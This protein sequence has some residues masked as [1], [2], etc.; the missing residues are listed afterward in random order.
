MFYPYLYEWLPFI[1]GL[2]VP[3]RA[4]ILVGL[5][6]ALLAGFGVR[7]L[8]GGRSAWLQRGVLAALVV[9]IAVDLRP[10]LRL[11]PVWLEPPPIYG[12][13]S[14][15]T[16]VVLAEFPF[17]GNP[18]GFTP[19]VPYMYFSLWHWAQM[20]NGYSGHYPPGQVDFE[21]A[22]KEFPGGASRRSVARARRDA[23]DHQLRALSRRL[24][25]AA[26][27]GRRVAR[28]SRRGLGQ[29]AGR[30]GAALRA[31]ADSRESLEPSRPER[32]HGLTASSR[33]ARWHDEHDGLLVIVIVSIVPSCSIVME[34]WACRFSSAS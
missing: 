25:R 3:A 17:G 34:P 9:A 10:V 14:G 13:V 23:R 2:R 12:L 16:D 30:A 19:N 26:R 7:R 1:R 27:G 22:L 20:I 32:C 8:L 18:R 29:V 11:E 4:S 6:L 28:V 15:A 24:R 33:R 21:V 5:T 31:D